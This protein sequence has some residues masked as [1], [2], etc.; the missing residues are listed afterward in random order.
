MAR[1]TDLPGTE[2]VSN[3]DLF[4]LP[5]DI[6]MPAAL[7][8]QIDRPNAQPYQAQIDR[9]GGQRPNNARG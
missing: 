8:G 4:E 6:L 1:L 9:R 2:P 7:E 3:A 5:C